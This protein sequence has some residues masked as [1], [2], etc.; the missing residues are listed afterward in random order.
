MNTTILQRIEHYGDT[1]HPRWL[2]LLRIALGAVLL[3]KGIQFVSNIEALKQIVADS[4]F[5]WLSFFIAH[6]VALVHLAGGPL[7]AAGLITRIAATFQIPV[8]IGAI[9]FVHKWDGFLVD[10]SELLFAI[11]ILMLLVFFLIYGSGP[12]SFDELMKR[13]KE[14]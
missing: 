6:Y 9:I 7:I 3:L 11:I 13:Q 14:K 4:R 8:L 5:P 1:H 10:G 2:D 12:F